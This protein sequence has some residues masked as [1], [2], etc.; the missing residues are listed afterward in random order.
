MDGN[1]STGANSG[2]NTNAAAGAST[3]TKRKITTSAKKR[4]ATGAPKTSHTKDHDV[5]DLSNPVILIAHNEHQQT[6][7]DPPPLIKFTLQL[8]VQGIKFFSSDL[9][10]KDSKT[11][12]RYTYARVDDLFPAIKARPLD[13]A[14]FK[15]GFNIA[16]KGLTMVT[17]AD[18]TM[19]SNTKGWQSIR[20]N[21]CAREGSYYCEFKVINGIDAPHAKQTLGSQGKPFVRFGFSRREDHLERPVGST[22]YGY[23]IRDVNGESRWNARLLPMTTG[24]NSE[25]KS[26]APIGTVVGLRINLPSLELHRKVVDGTYNKAVDLDTHETGLKYWTADNIVRDRLVVSTS[27]STR[28]QVCDYKP[29]PKLDGLTG[30]FDDTSE[31]QI[32]PSPNH[33]LTELRSLPGSS[34]QLYKNGKLVRTAFEDLLAFLPPASKP[35]NAF[36]VRPGMDDGDV[37]YFPTATCT[38][39]GAVELNCG[40]NFWFPPEDLGK[41]GANGAELQPISNRYDEQ[42]AESCVWDIID[43]VT[44]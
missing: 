35:E 10:G 7:R 41:A 15:A 11:D 28:L 36:G 4:D 16:E 37:G 6:S 43:E 29:N 9:V 42:V 26:F 12:Q 38:Y 2:A 44:Q 18:H 30:R 19:A 23:G 20:A 27:K 13:L 25:E 1:A 40:P 21:V 17:N 5:D 22:V 8:E 32:P 33:P 39:A 3:N 24:G 34:I 31:Y 14:P